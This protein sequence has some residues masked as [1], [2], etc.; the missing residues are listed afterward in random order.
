[1][2]MLL[3]LFVMRNKISNMN[4]QHTVL[5]LLE[6]LISKQA[7]NANIVKARTFSCGKAQLLFKI[8]QQ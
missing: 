4:E 1:M 8:F 2:K 6:Q 7:G 5:F 3:E